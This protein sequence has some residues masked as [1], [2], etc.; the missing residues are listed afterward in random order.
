MEK[1]FQKRKDF[2]TH[3]VLY[4]EKGSWNLPFDKKND[5]LLDYCKF[6]RQWYIA[7]KPGTTCPILVDV[8]L[9]R[10]I[11]PEEELEN[12][13][14]ERNVSLYTKQDVVDLVVHYQT[15]LKENI[16]DISSDSLTC[17]LLEKPSRLERGIRKHGFHLHF[18]KIFVTISDF[19]N[20]FQKFKTFRI[21]L[22]DVSNK[23]WLMYGSVKT[24]NQDPYIVTACFQDQG[25]EIDVDQAVMS[26]PLEVNNE[27]FL[28]FTNSI[29][30]KLVY[31]LSI[32]PL[33]KPTFK[34]K[35][36][37]SATRNVIPYN[38]NEDTDIVN[39]DDCDYTLLEKL[40]EILKPERADEYN[41]WWDIGIILYNVTNGSLRG[42][43][44]FHKF[45]KLSN[46]YDIKSVDDLWS[47]TKQSSTGKK[48]K[49][50]SLIFFCRQDDCRATKQVI[51]ESRDKWIPDTDYRLAI[52]FHQR[53]PDILLYC[54]FNGW[55]KFDAHCWKPLK[56]ETLYVIPLLIETS[57][58]YRKRLNISSCDEEKKQIRNVIKKLE[59]NASQL[60]I[61]K[62]SAHLYHIEDIHLLM[63]TNPY[64]ICFQ[65]GVYDLQALKFRDG[66]VQ[67]LLSTKLPV[68]YMEP[69]GEELEIFL[70]FFNRIFPDKEVFDYFFYI[71][72][73]L[74]VGGNHDKIG[75]F[76]TGVG[77]N[78]KSVTQK[79]FEIMLGPFGSKL[80]TTVITTKKV[81]AGAASPE[82]AKL[83]GGVRWTVFEEFN[84]DELINH[85]MFKLLTGN[86]S[87]YARALYKDGITFQPFFKLI[88]ICNDLPR[89]RGDDEATW[90][91]VRVIPFESQFC[92][93]PPEDEQEQVRTK[94]FKI[95][96]NIERHF[97]VMSQTLA[98]FLIER[99]KVKRYNNEQLPIPQKVSEATKK[100]QLK[101]NR[102]MYFCSAVLETCEPSEATPLEEL[103]QMARQFWKIYFSQEILEYSDFKEGMQRLQRVQ[104]KFFKK[105]AYEM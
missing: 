65:N 50:G 47:R 32:N 62:E 75:Q 4:G 86:D 43:E 71:T 70:Q 8:D 36:S 83:V 49:L 99:L 45:S 27:F 102:F 34:I 1:Y 25:I 15:I 82:L 29:T 97:K 91:R 105:P 52:D 67:D 22:D 35:Q 33:G 39:D 103:Y 95:D 73:E 53:F 84:E 56:D 41:T 90:I 100:Y 78:G 98:W 77:N 7:E 54:P 87:L 101:S 93:Y 6:D 21:P 14:F 48:K 2:Y 12:I 61:I 69:T 42:L 57:N 10:D 3:V 64:L 55:Y 28:N 79:L 104:R 37:F 72:C 24:K 31:I 16:I 80:P 23:T 5:F 63:N 11:E 58:W 89:F 30:A 92:E 20:L 13:D 94:T 44:L 59:T 60:T 19:K 38:A 66:N 9:K 68:S 85:G 74:F 81:K 51:F 76:W 46:K 18:P 88:A 26:W 17:F 40:V 96:K